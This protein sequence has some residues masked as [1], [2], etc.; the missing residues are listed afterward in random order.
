MPNVALAVSLLTSLIEQ[1]ASVGGLI[2]RAVASGTDLTAA[3]LQGLTD[4]N[5]AAQA[6]LDA[7]IAA[8]GASGNA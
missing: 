2:S 8:A 4:A 6:K 7:D 1:L 5:K 3:D